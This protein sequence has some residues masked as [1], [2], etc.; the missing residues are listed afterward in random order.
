MLVVMGSREHASRSAQPE[1]SGKLGFLDKQLCT[2]DAPAIAKRVHVGQSLDFEKSGTSIHEPRKK[3][4]NQANLPQICCAPHYTIRCTKVQVWVGEG[5]REGPTC[6]SLHCRLPG[7]A[8]LAQ[9]SFP[10]FFRVGSACL[11]TPLLVERPF[12][13]KQRFH[14]REFAGAQLPQLS[15]R[16]R[17]PLRLAPAGATP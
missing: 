15:A 1:H 6:L 3:H 2:E 8:I 7:T 14:L 17:L 12:Y 10:A 16:Y 13:I 11:P 9:S 5:P 4:R